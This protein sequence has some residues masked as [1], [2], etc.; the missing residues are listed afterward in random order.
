MSE[1][2]LA[3][4]KPQFQRAEY[5]STPGA[6]RCKSCNQP[7]GQTYYRV[8]GAMT[9]TT[10]GERAA[11]ALPKDS[12]AAFMRGLLFGIGGAV[13]GL[14]LYSAFSIVTGLII[15]YVSLAV[16]YIVGKAIMMGSRGI[17][18]RRY[19]ITAVALTYAAVSIA[20]VPIAIAQN[21]KE[22][23]AQ[24]AAAGQVQS[25]SDQNAA[26][27]SPT[28]TENSGAPK[29]SLGAA[30][31]QLA[32]LGLASP[33]LELQDPVHGGIGMIIL[34]VGIRIA[35]RL[36]AGTSMVVLGP[37]QNPASARQATAG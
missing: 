24:P 8:Q 18:G 37:F 17:G 32:L 11:S 15:G 29:Q 28:G 22:R 34:L 19:Q 33:F 26:S 2:S 14:I 9:C 12:H 7:I 25:L 36:A 10:C 20:A 16:G 23:K 1:D 3:G 21:M 5:A 35:W 31:G 6:E 27:G 30:L 13:L 4:S